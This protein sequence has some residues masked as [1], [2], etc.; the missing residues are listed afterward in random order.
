MKKM[1]LVLALGSVLSLAA[2]GQDNSTALKA[3]DPDNDG[4]IDLA[5][6]LFSAGAGDSILRSARER[7]TALLLI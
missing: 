1:A 6:A 5:E 2:C 7:A 4:T 3:L